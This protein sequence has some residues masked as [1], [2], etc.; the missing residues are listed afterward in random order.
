MRI[1]LV[2][3]DGREY[4]TFWSV[5]LLAGVWQEVRAGHGEA[6]IAAYNADNIGRLVNVRKIDPAKTFGDVVM[7]SMPSTPPP[8]IK[9]A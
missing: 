7:A 8:P 3:L 2:L 6:Q 1:K 4:Y 5:L 9:A